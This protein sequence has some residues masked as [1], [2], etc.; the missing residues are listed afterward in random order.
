MILNI[1]RHK[2]DENDICFL[3]DGATKNYVGELDNIIYK[4]RPRLNLK[5]VDWTSTDGVVIICGNEEVLNKLFV[6][7]TKEL[8]HRKSTNKLLGYTQRQIS[9]KLFKPLNR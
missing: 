7:I 3:I 9:E 2:R 4:Y 6:N 1:D 5:V 8:R